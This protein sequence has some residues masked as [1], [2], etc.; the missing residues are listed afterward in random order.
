M[1]P[2]SSDSNPD[3]PN[4]DTANVEQNDDPHNENALET[5]AST[6]KMVFA[7][8]NLQE[9]FLNPVNIGLAIGVAIAMTPGVQDEFFTPA[10]ALRWAGDSLT[11]IGSPTVITAQL[12]L[13]G[14]LGQPG[15]WDTGSLSNMGVAI[16][17][18]TRLLLVPSITGRIIYQ[19]ELTLTLTLTLTLQSQASSFIK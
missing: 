13:A 14:T 2:S 10:G 4:L 9:V 17:V 15:A 7:W 1:Y 18:L 12:V 19:V 16:L 8:E 5:A 3:I 6:E 11:V